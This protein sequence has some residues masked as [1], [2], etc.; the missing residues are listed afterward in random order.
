MFP[1]TEIDMTTVEGRKFEESEEHEEIN[2]TYTD[3]NMEHRKEEFKKKL[4]TTRNQVCDMD[5]VKTA[6][7]RPGSIFEAK[8]TPH[9]FTKSP[10]EESLQLPGNADPSPIIFPVRSLNPTKLK[11][12]SVQDQDD[13]TA[14]LAPQYMEKIHKGDSSDYELK[15]EESPSYILEMNVR[16][17]RK[18]KYEVLAKNE[19]IDESPTV[20]DFIMD[21]STHGDSALNDDDEYEP[22]GLHTSLDEVPQLTTQVQTCHQTV[23]EEDAKMTSCPHKMCLEAEHSPQIITQPPGAPEVSNKDKNRSLE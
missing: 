5:I 20:R 1:M 10:P 8:E 14:T 12:I 13:L 11:L 22:R 9:T 2:V 18:R 21:N 15:G 17:A 19:E 6:V 7:K 23:D 4:V 16:S 3:R